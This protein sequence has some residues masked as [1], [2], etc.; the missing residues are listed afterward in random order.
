ME[1]I[2]K[3]FLKWAGGKSQLLAEFGRLYPQELQN[4]SIRTY[5]E[6]FL[7]SGA[8]FF[9]L[10]QRYSIDIAYLSDINDELIITYKVVQQDVAKLLELLMKLETTYKKLNEASRKKYYY[11]ERSDYNQNRSGINYSK[12]THHW[13]YMAAQLIF[14]NRTCYNG[15]HRVNSKGEFNTPAGDYKNP[16]ICDEQNL[17]LVNRLLQRAEIKKAGFQELVHAFNSKSFVYF[18]PP[19]RPISKTASFNAYS[20]YEFTDREQIS[21]AQVYKQLDIEGAKLM[22]SNSDPKNSDPADDFFD[23]LY[24]GFQIQRIPAR[25]L[26]NSDAKKRSA[27]NEIVV[28]N[29]KIQ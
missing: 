9:D 23:N 13:V 29:Y 12:Y 18:D 10:V 21:L 14:L 17:V 6:P 15:L 16:T 20:K 19:Y 27:I 1:P 24:S 28:T 22:L 25:R 3:P 2:A 26:I 7:G 4:H 11:T 8:V 5:Y